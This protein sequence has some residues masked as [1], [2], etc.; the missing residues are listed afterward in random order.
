MPVSISDVLDPNTGDFDGVAIKVDYALELDLAFYILL[1]L[2]GH[3]VQWNLSEEH[4]RL[5]QDQTV[6]KS[7]QQMEQIRQY[8]LDATRYS[9]QLCRDAGAE[10]LGE[11]DRFVSDWFYADYKFLEH[12]YTTGERLDPRK[13]YEPGCG[14]VLTPL[15]IPAFTPQRWTSRWSF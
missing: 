2:F 12:F 4:R 5:G 1:H 10:P 14:E 8:E 11:I 9:L 13:L 15:E 6:P 3:S 7:P